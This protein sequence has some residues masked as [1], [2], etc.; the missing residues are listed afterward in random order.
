ML[1]LRLAGV[2]GLIAFFPIFWLFTWITGSNDIGAIIA[3]LL[4]FVGVPVLI[5][6]LW[7]PA[8]TGEGKIKNRVLGA[9]GVIWGGAVLIHGLMKGGSEGEGA[10][11]Q[12]QGG[13]LVFGGLMVAV[14]LYYL[15]KRYNKSDAQSSSPSP[16]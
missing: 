16:Q 11:A 7:R 6:K 15:L 3:L 12:A 5:H 4:G 2:A 1:R 8:A 14:G 13:A 10:Y 9:V